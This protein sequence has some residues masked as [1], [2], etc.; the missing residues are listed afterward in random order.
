MTGKNKPIKSTPKKK[1][2][3]V[4]TTGKPLQAKPVKKAKVVK[5]VGTPPLRSLKRRPLN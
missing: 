4:K 1:S 2:E 5:K 3:A